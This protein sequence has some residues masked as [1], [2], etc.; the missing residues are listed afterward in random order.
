MNPNERP[1]PYRIRSRP[2]PVRIFPRRPADEDSL[3][4]KVGGLICQLFAGEGH[5]ENIKSRTNIN[6]LIDF[7]LS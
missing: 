1:A 6:N 7:A 4:G 5:G 2:A 3:G